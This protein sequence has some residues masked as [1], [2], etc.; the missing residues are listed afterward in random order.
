MKVEIYS[1]KQH[2]PY[3]VRAKD[4]MKSLNM[5]FEEYMAGRDITIDELKKEVMK[6][7][8]V[9]VETVP[10]IFIDN[11]LIGG[12]DDFERWVNKNEVLLLGSD[13]VLDD[14]L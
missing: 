7:S 2:C 4:I 3:C 9:K 1:R 13:L 6:R 5:D 11:K 8:G 12:M 14:E 10:V